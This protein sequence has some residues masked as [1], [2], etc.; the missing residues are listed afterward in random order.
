MW[1]SKWKSNTVNSGYIEVA[2]DLGQLQ[3][4]RKFNMTELRIYWSFF[5]ELQYIRSLAI[6]KVFLKIQSQALEFFF[7]Q[8]YNCYIIVLC[9]KNS[10]KTIQVPVVA[11]EYNRTKFRLN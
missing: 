3:Y 7:T 1:L 5:L 2:G 6:L 9:K 8:Y 10:Q 4:N 11:I